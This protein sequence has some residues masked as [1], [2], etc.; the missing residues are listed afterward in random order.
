MPSAE[1]KHF[2]FLPLKPVTAGDPELVPA[3]SKTHSA[4]TCRKYAN[5]CT[6]G[7]PIAKRTANKKIRRTIDERSPQ[8]SHTMYV[9]FATPALSFIA[10]L[11]MSLHSHFATRAN[12]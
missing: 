2:P 6:F 4:T 8:G 7:P 5:R 10:I 1:R 12:L 9:L 11:A 3:A